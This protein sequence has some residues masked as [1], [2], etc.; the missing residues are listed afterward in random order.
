[1][2]I[3]GGAAHFPGERG[4]RIELPAN[5]PDGV[6]INTYPGVTF[7]AWYTEDKGGEAKPWQRLFDFGASA[8]GLDDAG[9]DGTGAYC[10]HFVVCDRDQESDA[11]LSNGKPSIREQVS[12]SVPQA[13][14]GREV[15]GGHCSRREHAD[16]LHRWSQGFAAAAGRQDTREG[17]Q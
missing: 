5:G 3:T 10:I 12:L 2:T 8:A 11:E 13:P 15:H 4:A 9:P 6:N 1:M 17:I 14:V 16:A 7:E